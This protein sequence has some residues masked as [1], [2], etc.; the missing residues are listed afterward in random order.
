MAAVGDTPLTIRAA[1]I[2]DVAA[3]CGLIQELGYDGS[4]DEVAARLRGILA[5]PDQAV[6]VAEQASAVLGWLQVQLTSV[7]ESDARGEIVGLVVTASR[8]KSGIGRQLVHAAENWTRSRG[9]CLVGVRCNQTRVDAH[10][11]Y[12]RLGFAV[13]KTQLSFRKRLA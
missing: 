9:L 8:R 12:E 7:L 13:A 3:L 10:R 4:P 2:G 5:D 11:F 1:A 6:F